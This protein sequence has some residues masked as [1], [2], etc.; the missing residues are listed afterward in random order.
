MKK[1]IALLL[2]LVMAFSVTTVAFAAG[3][4]ESSEPA[5]EETTV[6]AEGDGDKSLE[7]M[8]AEELI[9]YVM[10]LPAGPTLYALKAVIKVAKIAIKIAL[11]LDKIHIIDLSPIKNAI[12]EMVADMIRDALKDQETTDPEVT[13]E[14]EVP[15]ADLAA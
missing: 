8:N 14:P 12:F 10:N 1:I 4:N 9:E 7:D 3:E 15:E 11:V 6:P 13:A 2:A 5:A